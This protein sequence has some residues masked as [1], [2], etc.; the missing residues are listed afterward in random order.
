MCVQLCWPSLSRSC[1]IWLLNVLYKHLEYP[2]DS[3]EASK[4]SF[5]WT[6]W[7]VCGEKHSST[8][9]S[10]HISPEKSF[11]ISHHNTSAGCLYQK[12]YMGLFWFWYLWKSESGGAGDTVF[13]RM[14]RDSVLNEGCCLLEKKKKIIVNSS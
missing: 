6:V 8:I 14:I 7:I 4:E 9:L 1:C 5:P 3:P 2:A 12:I 11:L 13:N 10:I